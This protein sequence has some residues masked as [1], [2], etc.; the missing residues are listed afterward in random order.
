MDYLKE[1]KGKSGVTIYFL[2]SYV[3]CSHAEL[4]LWH[5][6]SAM[7]FWQSWEQ[8]W[9]SSKSLECINVQLILQNSEINSEMKQTQWNFTMWLFFIALF[10][11]FSVCLLVFVTIEVNHLT[12][13][14]SSVGHYKYMLQTDRSLELLVLTPRGVTSHYSDFNSTHDRATPVVYKSNVHLQTL[15]LW[16][17]PM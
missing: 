5:C 9:G 16:A 14:V 10:S 3:T 17:S 4:L 2:T 12:V 15:F 7:L 1:Q 11:L 6:I 13:A 8:I